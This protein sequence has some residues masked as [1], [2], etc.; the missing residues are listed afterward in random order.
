[1]TSEKEPVPEAD[2]LEQEQGISDESESD[3]EPTL[4]DPEAPEADALEQR[5]PV[6]IDEDDE[7]R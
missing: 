6:P 7:P 5:T 2:A 4:A 3:A 1:M